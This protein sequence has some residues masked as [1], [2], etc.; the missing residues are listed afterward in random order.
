MYIYVLNKNPGCMALGAK[1]MSYFCGSRV[2]WKLGYHL[3]L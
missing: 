3:S 1:T 2:F